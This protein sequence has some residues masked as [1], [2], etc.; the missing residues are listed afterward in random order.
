M[1]VELQKLRQITEMIFDHIEKDL[2]IDRVSLDQDY[3]WNIPSKVLHN[4]E[5]TQIVPDIGQL[6]DDLEFLENALS[7]KNQAVSLMFIHLAPLLR[8]IGEKTGQ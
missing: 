7:D 2:K 4:M 8:Y 6:Y 5:A 3:Y 1:E